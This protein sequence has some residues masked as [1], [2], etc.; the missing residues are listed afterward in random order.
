VRER[1]DGECRRY[2]RRNAA[3]VE[4]FA[5]RR[6]SAAKW[7]ERR[8]RYVADLSAVLGQA[9]ACLHKASWGR[10]LISA[11]LRRQADSESCGPE[12]NVP[13]TF[14]LYHPDCTPRRCASSILTCRGERFCIEFTFKLGRSIVY[15]TRNGA[16]RR[17]D[18]ERLGRYS[19][20][21]IEFALA[22]EVAGIPRVQEGK[23]WPPRRLPRL[24]IGR[25]RVRCGGLS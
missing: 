7:R 5:C 11:I 10:A 14:V 8:L 17:H 24:G 2:P 1:S 16:P 21:S 12:T 6:H 23:P 18:G 19:L 25:V 9:T 4:V 22:R 15:Q 20:E 3:P 13:L